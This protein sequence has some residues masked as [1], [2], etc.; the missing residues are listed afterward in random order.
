MERISRRQFVGTAATAAAAPALQSLTSPIEAVARAGEAK[1]GPRLV[2]IEKVKVFDP[3][4]GTGMGAVKNI[5][6]PQDVTLIRR[7]NQWQMY[8]GARNKER[9]LSVYSATLPPGAPLSATGWTITT[10]PGDPTTAAMLIPDVPVEQTAAWDYRRHNSSYVRG[11]DPD[12]NGGQGGWEE[13][14]YY[15]GDSALKLNSYAIGYF[16]WNGSDW[17]RRDAPVMTPTEPWESPEGTFA[18]VYEPNVIYHRGKWRMWYVIGPPDAEQRM[19]HGYAESRDGRTWTGKRIYWPIEENIFDNQV[20]SVRRHGRGS[21]VGFEACFARFGLSLTPEPGWGLFWQ[22]APHPFDEPRKWSEPQQLVDA[23]DGTPWH[24]AGVWTPSLHY[25]DADP[26]R[27]FVF[28]NG[29]YST[30]TFP[31][32]FTLGCVECRLER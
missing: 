6:P 10:V 1:G 31:P 7:G 16:A 13:R 2:P 9:R 26:E 17:V 14:L 21:R 32:A 19:A 24:A 3:T 29:G 4:D 23:A 30:A 11:W 28:F 8:C 22:H 18:G 5:G 20:L 27:A 12:L 15:T 25:S